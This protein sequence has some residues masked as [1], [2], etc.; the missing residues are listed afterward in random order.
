MDAEL[1]GPHRTLQIRVWLGQI[2]IAI[3]GLQEW[4]GFLVQLSNCQMLMNAEVLVL[5]HSS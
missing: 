5:Y 3:H 1:T 4:V 2:C